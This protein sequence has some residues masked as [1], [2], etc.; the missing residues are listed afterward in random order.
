[1]QNL[2]Q[3]V[4]AAAVSNAAPTG[5]SSIPIA[6]SQFRQQQQQHPQQVA[7]AGIPQS[8]MFFPQQYQAVLA[9]GQGGIQV[10]VP[11]QPHQIP[12]QAAANWSTF[13][14]GFN[15]NTP[16]AVTAGPNGIPMQINP[17]YI[18]RLQQQQQ[19]QRQQQQAQQQAQQQQQPTTVV[20]TPNGPITAPPVPGSA[21]ISGNGV[22][23]SN[24]NPQAN[25]PT[26]LNATQAAVVAA[27]NATQNSPNNT[28]ANTPQA[29]S[30]QLP[31]GQQQ[32]HPQQMVPQYQIQPSYQQQFLAAQM[33]AQM[34]AQAQAAQLQHA[35]AQAQAQ[36]AQ[37]QAAQVQSI[38]AQIP[39][40]GPGN[41][42]MPSPVPNQR[43]M[44]GSPLPQ[45]Q[46][47]MQQQ[48]QQR[49][50]NQLKNT[51]KPSPRP[52]NQNLPQ[53]QQAG[54]MPA[55]QMINQ[56]QQQQMNR[57]V[58]TQ[59]APSPHPHPHPSP[60]L[61]Q[62]ASPVLSHNANAIPKPLPQARHNHGSPHLGQTP[63]QSPLVRNRSSFS[64][65]DMATP[66]LSSGNPHVP[67]V[68]SGPNSVSTTITVPSTPA[69]TSTPIPMNQINMQQ[70]PQ[71]QFQ[72]QQQPGQIPAQF[73]Q[74][75]TQFALQQQ[76]QL[77]LQKLQ[78]QQQQQAQAQ[79]Q[80]QQAQA[81]ARAQAQVQA[82]MQ[83][84]HLQQQAQ[85][86]QVQQAQQQAQVQ[87]NTPGNIQIA[88]H[89]QQPNNAQNQFYK[90]LAVLKL[91][92]FCEAINSTSESRF[93]QAYWKQ[94]INE[95]FTD[96]AV[97]QYSICDGEDRKV[98]ELPAA[99]LPRFYLTFIKSGVERIQTH[100]E[101]CRSQQG[102]NCYIVESPK[103]Y[104]THRH[105]D[106]SIVTATATIRAIINP[107]MKIEY[108]EQ[109]TQ[110]HDEFVKRNSILSF[111]ENNSIDK[112]PQTKLFPYGVTES[113]LTFL[114][115]SDTMYQMKELMMQSK[116][117]SS[118]GP[119]K[120]FQAIASVNT[121]QMP[122]GTES[123]EAADPNFQGNKQQQSI[124]MQQQ[125]Q[126]Q[127]NSPGI[128]NGNS[129]NFKEGQSGSAGT[130]TMANGNAKKL[131]M[132]MSNNGSSPKSNNS[133]NTTNNNNNNNSTNNSITATS[134]PLSNGPANRPS[135]GAGGGNMAQKRR[136]ANSRNDEFTMSPK[137]RTSS[138]K[139][140]KRV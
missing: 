138:P 114:Q 11:N 126:N 76:Q 45:N 104:I 117:P 56:Q 34:Q 68:S 8:Q 29:M 36:A 30:Q 18:Q 41:Q 84:Q 25:Q 123:E 3:Q 43:P 17:V 38:Q 77:Q 69:T 112:P 128:T 75:Q 78:Q 55:P 35:Q 23:A 66:D 105:E 20:S 118:G 64:S 106:G 10:Q 37:A 27:A 4:S 87:L 26:P 96:T 72:L 140:A 103:A 109:T 136:R 100:L 97:L 94:K 73:A 99:I 49:A 89:T 7:T 14:P 1:M 42:H 111:L 121:I 135:P 86:A 51:P 58:G 129:D 115:V 130:P 12:V 107:R 44:Q 52:L 139:M 28:Q 21:A 61:Q 101:G 127:N 85:H 91:M 54:A 110:D 108:M 2:V 39:P 83:S 95:Y 113:V 50:A 33:Q 119:Y 82:R 46:L 116:I 22:G 9:Q 19:Q 47:P 92:N 120:S 57:Q 31:H 48:Q 88:M 6:M 132:N 102:N 65:K 32:F 137:L 122:N 16:T 80:A 131:D 74:Q 13:T 24:G 53:Q 93:D 67:M 5:G 81:Q 133:N 71:A 134:S 63:H 90:Q 79:A 70:Q 98:F 60:H 62:A 124:E 125:N 15:N 40:Q 59:P